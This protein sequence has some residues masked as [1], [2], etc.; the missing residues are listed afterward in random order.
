MSGSLLVI[1]SDTHIGG[2]TA[3]ATPEYTVHNRYDLEAQTIHANRLQSWLWECW[4]D[5]WS[6][7]K[8]LQ[9]K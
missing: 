6:Y 9:G 4:S 7:V 8:E 5:F 3:L 2:S 1:I